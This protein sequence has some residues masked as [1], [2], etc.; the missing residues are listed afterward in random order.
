VIFLKTNPLIST[1]KQ[2]IICKIEQ[3]KHS[4]NANI[5]WQTQ[6]RIY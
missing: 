6:D 2:K 5:V 4:E 3:A 1:R